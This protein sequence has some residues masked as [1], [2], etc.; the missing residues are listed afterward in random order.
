M[1]TCAN[2]GQQSPDGTYRCGHCGVAFGHHARAKV[3]AQRTNIVKAFRTVCW[4]VTLVV[5][6][7]FAPRV[8]HGAFATY[9]KYRL[10]SVKDGAMKMCKG[11]ATDAM[12]SYER[13]Q[14]DQCLAADDN[15]TKA[16]TDY[17]NYTKG[18]KH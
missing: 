18:D 12:P 4:I 11:P 1:I 3:D 14:I 6:V 7:I 15:L 10:N 9:Y 13:A 5:V 8:Y 2:C 17:D 16:Q